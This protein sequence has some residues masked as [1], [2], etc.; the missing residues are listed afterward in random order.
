MKICSKATLAGLS[1]DLIS[2]LS[3]QLKG[4]MNQ[5]NH[6]LADRFVN[7]RHCNYQRHLYIQQ[8]DTQNWKFIVKAHEN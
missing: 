6:S 2:V 1:Q 8:E 7:N 5:N 3:Q 4:S